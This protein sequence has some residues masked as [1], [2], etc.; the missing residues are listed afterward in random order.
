MDGAVGVL[1]GS[2][3]MERGC[4]SPRVRGRAYRA[5]QPVRAEEVRPMSKAEEEAL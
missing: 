1:E 2:M 4:L 3:D 5:E